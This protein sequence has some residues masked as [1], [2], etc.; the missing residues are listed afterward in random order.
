[1]CSLKARGVFAF[2]YF[3]WSIVLELIDVVNLQTHNVNMEYWR[4]A[5]SSKNSLVL[6]QL[7]IFFLKIYIFYQV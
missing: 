3:I 2:I 6:S 4:Q 1:M 5:E 7:P